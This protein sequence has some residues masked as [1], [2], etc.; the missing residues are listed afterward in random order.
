VGVDFQTKPQCMVT[1]K[2]TSICKVC[3][4]LHSCIKIIAHLPLV[5]KKKYLN[6]PILQNKSKK[7]SPSFPKCAQLGEGSA[8]RSALFWCQSGIHTPIWISIKMARLIRIGIIFIKK[9]PIHNTDYY[10]YSTVPAHIIM[11]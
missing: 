3:Y 1:W 2:S 5:W 9:M 10:I 8:I 11:L 6:L 7:I 4:V